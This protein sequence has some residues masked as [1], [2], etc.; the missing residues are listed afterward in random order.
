MLRRNKLGSRA[1]IG[2]SE[3]AAPISVVHAGIFAEVAPKIMTVITL[4]HVYNY[5]SGY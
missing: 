3:I 2:I 5:C 4:I 1:L